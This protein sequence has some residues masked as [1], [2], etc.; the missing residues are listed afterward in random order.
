MSR[1]LTCDSC[2][3]EKRY[4]DVAAAPSYCPRCGEQWGPEYRESA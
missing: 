3:C 2:G 1:T 4:D